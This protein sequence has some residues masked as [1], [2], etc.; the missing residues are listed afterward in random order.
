[1]RK[2]DDRDNI[3]PTKKTIDSAHDSKVPAFDDTSSSDVAEKVKE[4]G[5]G[6]WMRFLTTYP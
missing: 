4:Y 5:Y 6:F 2:A 3:V 1:L